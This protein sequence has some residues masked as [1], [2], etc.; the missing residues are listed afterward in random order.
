MLMQSRKVEFEV[1]GEDHAFHL[2][3]PDTE[4]AKIMFKALSFF[5][6]KH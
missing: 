5:L 2:F 4:N 6:N 3:N 1:K